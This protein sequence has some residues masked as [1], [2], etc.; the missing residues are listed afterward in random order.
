MESKWK[1]QNFFEA[2]KNAL[3]GIIYI[4]KKERNIKIELFFALLAIIFSIILK[5]SLVE[6]AVIVLIIS[7]VFFSEFINTSLEIAID[8]YTQEYNEKVKIAKDISAGAVL[9]V[10]IASVIIGFLIFLPKILKIM[11]L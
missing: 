3:N 2:F 7:L 8:L 4:I 11:K 6:M 5:I 9:L 10:S 1:N